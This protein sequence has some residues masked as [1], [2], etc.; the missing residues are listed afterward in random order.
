MGE[1]LS[2]GGFSTLCV[3]SM[4]HGSRSRTN[5]INGMLQM[6]SRL[7]GVSPRSHLILQRSRIVLS[8]VSRL[9][10]Y[11]GVL[12]DSIYTF[13]SSISV[14]KLS[15]LRSHMILMFAKTNPRVYPSVRWCFSKHQE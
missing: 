3:L 14:V 1:P 15:L 12:P 8:T 4:L 11:F 2:E 6:V 10:Y 13:Q 5:F 9:L 7:L